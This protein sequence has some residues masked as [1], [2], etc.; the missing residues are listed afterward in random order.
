[1]HRH[2]DTQTDVQMGL[3]LELTPLSV[4]QLKMR[5]MFPENDSL[6]SNRHTERFKVPWA[7]LM[8][9]NIQLYL[10]QLKVQ[11]KVIQVRVKLC[12]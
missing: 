12:L 4:G 2:S 3:D 6:V 5:D 7:R 8:N 1:M 11:T 10:Y 9:C